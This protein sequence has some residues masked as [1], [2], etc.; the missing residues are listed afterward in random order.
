MQGISW[1]AKDLVA[2]QERLC[3]MEF[4]YL[5]IYSYDFN[6]TLT[7]VL[8][9]V[10]G[11]PQKLR[12]HLL[13]ANEERLLPRKIKSRW[14]A[15]IFYILCRVHYGG[16]CLEYCLPNVVTP[17]ILVQIFWRFGGTYWLHLEIKEAV[18]FSKRWLSTARLPSGTS[19]KVKQVKGKVHPCTGTEALYRP[20]GP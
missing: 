16:D 19:Q 11:N 12:R 6:Y 9:L 13:F 15:Q 2:F 10:S 7:S 18:I 8:K 3:C 1:L 20:Y 5:F 14:N 17:C 4:I